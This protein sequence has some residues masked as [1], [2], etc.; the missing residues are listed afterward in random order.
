MNKNEQ[1]I[2][3]VQWVDVS[4]LSANDYNPNVVLNEEMKCC[5]SPS[6]RV[7]GFSLYWSRKTTAL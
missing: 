7:D 4:K 3:N 6:A 5:F 1:P 2:S